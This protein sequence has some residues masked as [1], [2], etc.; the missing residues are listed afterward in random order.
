MAPAAESGWAGQGPPPKQGKKESQQA[1]LDKLDTAWNVEPEARDAW[2]QDTLNGK[3]Q[4]MKKSETWKPFDSKNKVNIVQKEASQTLGWWASYFNYRAVL[5]WRALFIENPISNGP[6]G[7]LP[8]DS[9]RLRPLSASAIC[10]V[11]QKASTCIHHE[12]LL[13]LSR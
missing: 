1:W 6:V 8:Q 4:S 3:I 12:V 7:V 9:C 5:E 2:L 13:H 10:F 11:I